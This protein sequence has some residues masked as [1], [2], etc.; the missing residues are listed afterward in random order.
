MQDEEKAEQALQSRNDKLS[1]CNA[2]LATRV[3]QLEKLLASAVSPSTPTHPHPSL[4]QVPS[5]PCPLTG[6][7]H[8]ILLHALN[9]N[10]NSATNCA[11]DFLSSPLPSRGFPCTVAL[12]SVESARFVKHAPTQCRQAHAVSQAA[13]Q[14]GRLPPG[15]LH[16]APCLPPSLPAP[17]PSRQSSLSLRG[18]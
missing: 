5:H 10:A 1:K 15:S 11:S 2:E 4:D 7:L 12:R 17:N 3:K 9:C 18:S 16:P 6:G 14:T 8:I 13:A